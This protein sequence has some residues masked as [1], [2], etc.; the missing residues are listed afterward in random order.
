MTATVKPLFRR[1]SEHWLMRWVEKVRPGFYMTIGQTIYY[2]SDMEVEDI[3]PVTI[4]HEKVHIEQY[5]RYGIPLFL[6]MYFFVPT[7]RWRLERE[8]YLNEIAAGW[9]IEYIVDILRRR[10]LCLLPGR[11][12]MVRWF[13]EHWLAFYQKKRGI[14]LD[15]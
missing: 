10:Y 7:M 9:D 5:M 13:R 3:N 8:A 15:D 11:A 12:S 2:P 1:M 4:D 6:F 14:N